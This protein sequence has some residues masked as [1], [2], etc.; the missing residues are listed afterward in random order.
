MR[1]FTKIF[2]MFIVGVCIAACSKTTDSNNTAQ[3]AK[4]PVVELYTQL[5]NAS[6]EGDLGK[7]RSLIKQGADVNQLVLDKED[8]EK[9]QDT[10]LMLASQNGHLEVVKELLAAG[11]NVNQTLPVETER[12]MLPGENDTALE[13]ACRLDNMDIVNV[14][15]QAGTRA[16]SI[17]LCACLIENEELLKIA[18]QHKPNLNFTT[19]DGGVSPLMMMANKGN[20]KMVKALLE[21]GADPN[22]ADPSDPDYTALQ[23]A[24]DNPEIV[25]LL[26]F[27]GATQ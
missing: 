13:M 22:Y 15:A 3:L 20:T 9:Y 18:L 21:A 27:Y 17:L 5:Q 19:G 6:R 8:P 2:T 4:I 12:C 24:K 1:K 26:K 14:L 23:E 16:E 25:E 10:P 7:V 11:A